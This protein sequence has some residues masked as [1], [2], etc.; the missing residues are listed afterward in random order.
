MSQEKNIIG[1][2]IY[3]L[4]NFISDLLFE[5]DKTKDNKLLEI[6][7]IHSEKLDK[8]KQLFNSL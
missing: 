3:N 8:H 4:Q 5:L 1:I 6:L 2:D 7:K